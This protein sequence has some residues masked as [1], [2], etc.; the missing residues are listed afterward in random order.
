MKS[1][2]DGRRM[3]LAEV[4]ERRRRMIRVHGSLRSA[5][6]FN[7]LGQHGSRRVHQVD[8]RWSLDLCSGCAQFVAVAADDVAMRDGV[9]LAM[10]PSCRAVAQPM[11]HT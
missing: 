6:L 7:T 3:T 9:A 2:G 10:C 5:A 1:H 11:A 8:R 4:I